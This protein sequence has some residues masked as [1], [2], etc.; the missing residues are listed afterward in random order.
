MRSLCRREDRR[1][2]HNVRVVR[3]EQLAGSA[4]RDEGERKRAEQEEREREREEESMI[5]EVCN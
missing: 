5:S 1:G 4:R 3:G 2:E